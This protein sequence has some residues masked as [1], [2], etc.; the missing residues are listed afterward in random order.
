MPSLFQR[1]LTLFYLLLIA[2]VM[3]AMGYILYMVIRKSGFDYTMDKFLMTMI[4]ASV[5]VGIVALLM[6]VWIAAQISRPLDIITAGVDNM[7]QGN[8]QHRIHLLPS[9]ELYHL[10]QTINEMAE[11]LE[12]NLIEISSVRNRLALVLDT[13]VNGIFTVSQYGR[14]TYMNRRA[15]KILGIGPEQLGQKHA[16]VLQNYTLVEMIDK[17]RVNYQPIRSEI[18]F[19]GMSDRLLEV[20]VVPLRAGLNGREEG[21]LAI[22]NDITELKRLERVRK[23]FVGNISHELLTPVTT[24]TGYAENLMQSQDM[25]PDVIRQ[26]SAV[27]YDE[28]IRLQ[29]LISRLMELSRIESGRLQLHK[30][31]LDLSAVIEKSINMSRRDHEGEIFV[32]YQPPA[33]PLMVDLDEELIVQVM[34]NLLD[35]A[36]KFSP[37]GSPVVIAVEDHPQEV[38]IMVTNQ[39]EG[40]P[41]HEKDRIFERFYRV[42]KERSRDTGGFGLGLSIVKHLV[43]HHNGRLGVE[44]ELGCGA[45]F[46]FTLPR[47]SEDGQ[48]TAQ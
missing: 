18:K 48:E 11:K 24:I 29:R 36:I 46:F 40:I 44:S 42:D 5:A 15:S 19:H 33:H 9:D 37:P 14:I 20:N 6:N 25:A 23:D 4:L 34:L 3:V 7:A 22:F 30:Q 16:E 39:G 2:A 38:K 10:G 32:E 47:K 43:E 17:V 8:L 45:T 12:N 41:P 35:N 1:R 21:T 26:N 27:I 13:T 28:A 31:N